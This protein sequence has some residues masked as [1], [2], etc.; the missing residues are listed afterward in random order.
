MEPKEALDVGEWAQQLSEQSPTEWE[1][2]ATMEM[3]G[4]LTTTAPTTLALVCDPIEGT[5]EATIEAF[6]SQVSALQTTANK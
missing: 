4:Q 1:G 5:K 6:A 2:A 3:Q